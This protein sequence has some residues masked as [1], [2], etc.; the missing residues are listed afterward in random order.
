MKLFCA[1]FAIFFAQLAVAGNPI[2][3]DVHTADPA[4]IVVGDTVYLYV[5]HDQAKEN[6]H[7]YRMHEWLCYSSQDMKTWKSHGSPLKP[8]DFEWAND[9]A[10]ASE[11][12]E[13][14]GKHYWFVTTGQ[15]SGGMAIGV[16]V[17]DSPTGPF[18]DAIGKPLVT[19][20]MTPNNRNHGWEDID[21]TVFTD[22]DG[23]TY[24]FWGNLFC[25]YAKLKPNLI[26]LD[27]PIHEVDL[28]KFE[29][30]PWIHKRGDLYYL[31]YA[32]GFP[33][34]CAYAISKSIAGPWQPR[35]LL[36]EAA[37]NSNTI[38]PAIIEFKGQWYFIYHTGALDRPMSGSSHRRSVCID[39][40]YYNP[41]GTMRRVI[42]TTEGLDLPPEK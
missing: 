4:A 20:D 19:P 23:T 13:Q 15:K 37:G 1:V 27:G 12:M 26:E 24:L 18:R 38:H 6:E 36:A 35:G 5:G 28:P 42:Q 8:K 14:E 32:S 33:E 9:G 31:T 11:V 3:T 39:Y 29:E 30:A 7:T 16:A 22:D 25:Y 21:P 41:D 2:I 17:A 34:K 10:W 40:L